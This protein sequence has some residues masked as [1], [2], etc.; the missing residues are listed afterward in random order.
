MNEKLGRDVCKC[1]KPEQAGSNTG[2]A[3][4]L[5]MSVGQPKCYLSV[6]QLSVQFPCLC[7]EEEVEAWMGRVCGGRG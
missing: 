3:S 1:P 5:R 4:A 7:W 2:L 6:S